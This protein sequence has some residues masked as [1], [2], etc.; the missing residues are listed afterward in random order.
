M[1]VLAHQLVAS[2]AAPRAGSRGS[3]SRAVTGSLTR[4]GTTCSAHG[5]R[6]TSRAPTASRGHVA[7]PVELGEPHEPVALPS[8]ARACRRRPPPC[9]VGDTGRAPA[10]ARPG[11]PRARPAS[12]ARAVPSR[13]CIQP[14]TQTA[15]SST[16]M[17]MSTCAALCS[18]LVRNHLG[19][20]R[21]QLLVQP[22]EQ[23]GERERPAAARGSERPP[24]TR[25]CKAPRAL[26][27]IEPAQLLAHEGG[28]VDRAARASTEDVG[29]P[30]APTVMVKPSAESASG[31]P[32][33]LTASSRLLG[34]VAVRA[35][36]R[37]RVTTSSVRSPMAADESRAPAARPR[38]P[39]RRAAARRPAS[40]AARSSISLHPGEGPLAR[41][42]LRVEQLGVEVGEARDVLVH[43][44][45]GGA[46]ERAAR[47]K[48]PGVVT[49]A[50]ERGGEARRDRRRGSA[51]RSTPSVTFSAIPPMSLQITGRP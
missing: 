26:L 46:A 39:A 14:S 21:A 41:A 43:A 8:D 35:S 45:H 10:A 23:L 3:A 20:R 27:G 4:C 7:R 22:R 44:V 30:P 15:R 50:L 40:H 2:A 1:H 6:W 32:K 37:A 31:V 36:A 24:S 13:S 9:R 33:R 42:V 11:H 12:G 25:K 19:E 18:S 48:G 29:R 17:A 16:F 49:A 5:S 38:S 34:L 51:G 47:P 28:R